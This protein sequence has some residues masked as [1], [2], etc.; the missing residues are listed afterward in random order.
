M[1]SSNRYYIQSGRFIQGVTKE[2]F[3]AHWRLLCYPI[4]QIEDDYLLTV[5]HYENS[6][7]EF[8]FG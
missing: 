2:L 4:E 6:T 7:A 8:Y 3:L 1:T 5:N